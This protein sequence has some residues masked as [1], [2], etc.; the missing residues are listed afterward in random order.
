MQDMDGTT[1]PPALVEAMRGAFG[2][3]VLCNLSP[4]EY[5]KKDA[6]LF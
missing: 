3:Y 1:M 4:E 5:G 2:W 6:T